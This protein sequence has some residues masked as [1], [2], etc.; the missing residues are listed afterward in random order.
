M[1]R[2]TSLIAALIMLLATVVVPPATATEP[3][4]DDESNLEFSKSTAWFKPGGTKFTNL[5][6]AG[7]DSR[8]TWEP[9]PPT[10][11]LSEGGG[12]GYA[13]SFLAQWL[14]PQ[15]RAW[16]HF[17]GMVSGCLDVIAV[18][19]YL[20]DP[21]EDVLSGHRALVDLSID[22]VT[23]HPSRGQ[24]GFWVNIESVPD[25][26]HVYRIKFA[27]V[28]AYEALRDYAP[29]LTGEPANL[30]GEHQ[31]SLRLD[32]DRDEPPSP[33]PREATGHSVYLYDATEVPS[34]LV[35]NG[36][37]DGYTVIWPDPPLQP[38]PPS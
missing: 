38:L 22:G 8:P 16:T 10:E 9:E 31:I 2:R 29:I 7:A 25:V 14:V 1:P 26:A 3:C 13:D 21:A 15:R 34:N 12:A 23:T 35:F 27:F 28:D 19:M 24:G 17:E 20:F 4:L 6:W 18:E 5:S 33:L 30:D 36:D 11:S 37:T 32:V